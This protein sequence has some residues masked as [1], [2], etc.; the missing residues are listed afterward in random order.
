TEE[1]MK[2]SVKEWLSTPFKD[3]EKYKRRIAKMDRIHE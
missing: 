1:E 2:E 3:T